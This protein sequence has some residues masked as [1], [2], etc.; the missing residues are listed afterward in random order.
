VLGTNANAPRSAQRSPALRP[1]TRLYENSADKSDR[2]YRFR[3]LDG[4]AYPG[5]VT[6]SATGLPAGANISFTPATVAAHGGNVSVQT[7]PQR[8]AS[9]LQTKSLPILL[10]VLI[11]PFAGSRRMRKG[12]GRYL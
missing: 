5:T 1:H 10:G 12:A 8:A 11:L 2:T 3:L 6:F 9:N 7:A 4:T